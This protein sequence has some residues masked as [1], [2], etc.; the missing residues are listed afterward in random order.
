M[1]K[2]LLVDD[3]KRALEALGRTLQMMGYQTVGVSNPNTAQDLLK[4]ENYDILIADLI[5]PE[6]D[7]I[8]LLEFSKRI[9]PDLPVIILTGYGTVKTAVEA[10]KKG[11]FD[12]VTKPYHIDEIDLTIKRALQQRNLLL[13]NKML[14]E[15]LSQRFPFSTIITEDE[16]MKRIFRQIETLAN[17]DSTVLITGESGTGKELIARALHFSG[18]R[19]DAPFV[20]IDCGGLTETILE[21]EI[22]G[23]VKGAFT[24]AYHNKKGYL[25]VAEG[26]TLFFDE[27]GELPYPL[28]KKLLRVI[29]EREFS[30]VGDTKIIKTNVRILAATN[31][32]LKSEVAFGKFREDLYY[33]LNVISL[34]IPPLKKRIH[35]IPLLA[36]HFL[37]EFNRRFNKQVSRITEEALSKMMNYNWPGNIRE[38]KNTIEKIMNFKEG[39]TITLEDLPEEIRNLKDDKHS[40]DRP[41]KDIKKEVVAHISKDYIKGLLSL[42]KGNVSKAALKAQMDRGNFQKLMK[43][44]NISAKDFR[45]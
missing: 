7:G 36:Y 45:R 20:I 43:R 33:R 11:A 3:E 15:T 13:E 22:F 17:T 8:G 10:M 38:L 27:I 42:H 32:D 30:K 24:G 5:M 31:K 39:E 37:R 1:T 4:K 23:H 16:T 35:D 28:Q 14:R 9:N 2:I 34:H 26:G 29:Q 18:T 21:S 25:E 6:V 40:F 12:Y 19:H 41:F 44:F